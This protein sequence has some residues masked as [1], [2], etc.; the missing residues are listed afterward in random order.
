[1]A[2]SSTP[3]TTNPFDNA[4]EL[5]GQSP[6][7]STDCIHAEELD[8]LV[9]ALSIKAE[10]SGRIILLRS[11]RAG[12]GKT[13][14][15]IRLNE[16]VASTHDFIALEPSRGRYLNDELVLDAVLRN[17][18]RML[19]DGDG[20]T[21]LDKLARRIFAKGLEPLVLS[22]EVPSQDKESALEAMRSR[23][24][25]TFDFHNAEAS[26]AQWALSNF[27]LLGPRLSTELAEQI[28]ARYRPVAWWIELLF[29]Y[30]SASLEQGNRNGSL[31]ETVF[32]GEQHEA[33]MH[34][35]LVT[36]LNL[37]GLV[38]SPVLVLDEVEGLSSSPESGLEIVTFLNA[39]HQSC[40]KMVL[41]ISV[42]GDVWQTAFLPR[43]PCGLKDRLTDIVV[44][45]K[46]ITKEQAVRILRDRAGDC[47]D[48]L[49][50]A[51]DFDCGVVYPRGIVRSAASAWNDIDTGQKEIEVADAQSEESNA[52]GSEVV[53]QVE[54]LAGA[55]EQAT[56]GVADVPDLP[57]EPV[58]LDD[59]PITEAVIPEAVG[60]ID[61]PFSKADEDAA[62]ESEAVPPLDLET[63]SQLLGIQTEREEPEKPGA[64]VEHVMTQEA[65]PASQEAEPTSEPEPISNPA[66]AVFPPKLKE[67]V[68]SSA[69]FRP[70]FAMDE[71]E[72]AGVSTNTPEQDLEEQDAED[73]ETAR[74]A[75]VPS[76]FTK[77]P[78]SDD[79]AEVGA[80][81]LIQSPFAIDTSPIEDVDDA[82]EAEDA[83]EVATSVIEE[84][85]EEQNTDD[86]D[87]VAQEL[88]P[89]PFSM[90]ADTN[91]D[92]DAEVD[93]DE[94]AL[95]TIQSPFDMNEGAVEEVE[96]VES[97]EIKEAD[98]MPMANPFATGDGDQPHTVT[99]EDHDRIEDLL[100]QFRDRYGRE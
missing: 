40:K 9:E 28:E 90:V 15:L 36:L 47:A 74:E 50:E 12:F 8:R 17:F 86:A 84:N 3:P 41:I 63:I 48:V 7:V 82:A 67:E 5:F 83:A 53:D 60:V 80:E 27:T 19:P 32:N 77:V 30:S 24:A 11:P 1:M 65:E 81:S 70:L 10:N 33:D 31:F 25:E 64:Q 69:P 56:E 85:L 73:A 75:F 61:N 4:F 45:L 43:L 87:P 62:T 72:A 16:R 99:Q 42:N 2:S 96:E 29:R 88:A 71:D 59:E 14:L 21:Y 68:V 51:I 94:E 46:P 23:P 26:T 93:P 55:D 54:E 95:N 92:T 52:V 18:S 44:D 6:E 98:V 37:I 66:D 35:K 78:D 38:T 97:E 22:G 34:E 58:M 100:K 79:D 49:A 57:D 89:S 13:H 76:P 20:L 91:A 39:L